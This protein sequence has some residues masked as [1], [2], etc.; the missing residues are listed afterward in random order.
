LTFQTYTGYLFYIGSNL[1]SAYTSD[2]KPKF[3]KI[4]ALLSGGSNVG[5][6]QPI[7]AAR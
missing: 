2:P 4:S 1:S 7:W 5:L 3:P 6:S